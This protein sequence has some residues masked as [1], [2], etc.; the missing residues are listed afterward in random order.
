MD[1]GDSVKNSVGNS[2]SE[3]VW[4]GSLWS[5]VRDSVFDLVWNSVFD[6]V[7]NSVR[8]SVITPLTNKII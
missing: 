7:W 2:V 3:L 6:L 8:D 5:S 1:L 4:G